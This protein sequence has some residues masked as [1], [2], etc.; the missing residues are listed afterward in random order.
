MDKK[1]VLRKCDVVSR[2]YG[3]LCPSH[4]WSF[5]YGNWRC[6]TLPVFLFPNL[7]SSA[8][9][10]VL[11]SYCFRMKYR[12][13]DGLKCRKGLWADGDL[14]L[15]FSL[16]SNLAWWH[17]R[18]D[19]YF[20]QRWVCIQALPPVYCVNFSSLLNSIRFCSLSQIM[21]QCNAGCRCFPEKY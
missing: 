21:K 15:I 16:W 11:S 10:I 1:L 17:K 9:C 2:R 4:H 12:A 13:E 6:Q 14:L 20:R 3:L 18:T 19:F 8:C 7:E 5:S